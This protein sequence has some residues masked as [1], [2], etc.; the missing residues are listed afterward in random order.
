VGL[1]SAARGSPGV[2]A[3]VTVGAPGEIFLTA[4][5]VFYNQ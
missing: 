4:I 3:I 2:S 1:R 5:V